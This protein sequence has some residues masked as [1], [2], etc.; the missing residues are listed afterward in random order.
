MTTVAWDGQMMAADTLSTDG[1]GLKEFCDQKIFAGKDFLVGCAGEWGQAYKWWMEV[2]DMT[3]EEIIQRG[4]VGW[5]KDNYDP[6]LMLV[7]FPVGD[8]PKIYRIASGVFY[9]SPN[10][11]LA[12]GSGRDFAIASMFWGK[13][14]WDAVTC[15]REFDNNTG[16]SIIVRTK[17]DCRERV[18]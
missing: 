14:A 5:S 6:T 11:Q 12:I 3:G 13:T 1:W 17:K 10:R 9:L 18:I 8:T 4:I 2:K 7:H 16:G 15:A